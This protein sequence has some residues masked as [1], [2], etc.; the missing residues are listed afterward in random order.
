MGRDRKKLLILCF[1][2]AALFLSSL[3]HAA[4]AKE[5]GALIRFWERVRA[6]FVAPKEVPG[7]PAEPVPAKKE[8]A[9][10]PAAKPKVVL[11]K[12]GMIEAIEKR[13]DAYPEVLG[14]RH[15]AFVYPSSCL[16]ASGQYRYEAR[17]SR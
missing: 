2:L 12:D 8:E 6:R 13:L 14:S 17:C 4:Q 7:K 9:K 11:S 15:W 1:L 10:K 5:K 3:A 16:Q